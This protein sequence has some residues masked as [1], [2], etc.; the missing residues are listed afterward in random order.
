MKWFP[1]MTEEER[2]E[3]MEA[4]GGGKLCV[5]ADKESGASV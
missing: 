2:M 4:G 3:S 1:T 5:G